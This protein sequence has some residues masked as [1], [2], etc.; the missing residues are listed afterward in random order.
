M[1][2]EELVTALLKS[3]EGT[4]RFASDLQFMRQLAMKHRGARKAVDAFV[5]AMPKPVELVVTSIVKPRS[6]DGFAPIAKEQLR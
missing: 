2:S 5:A 4:P 1:P 6:A 3:S